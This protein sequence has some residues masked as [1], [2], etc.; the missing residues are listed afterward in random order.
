MQMR[1]TAKVKTIQEFMKGI[2]LFATGADEMAVVI[3]KNDRYYSYQ[4]NMDASGM[5]IASDLMRKF[6]KIT[7][8]E[9][10]L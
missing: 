3:H 7:E 9:T 10:D 6:T 1:F 8:E 2:N 5:I 4:F